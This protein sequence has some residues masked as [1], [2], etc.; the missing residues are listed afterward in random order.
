MSKLTPELQDKFIHLLELGVP[1][2]YA[3]EALNIDERTYFVWMKL[4]RKKKDDKY[5]Q[6]LQSVESIPGKAMARKLLHLEKAAEKGSVAASIW[7]LEHKYPDEFKQQPTEVNLTLKP[8]VQQLN[9]FYLLKEKE[10][11]KEIEKK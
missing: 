5:F 10:K 8:T 7:F 6:F 3:C 2:K 9:D 11:K 1:I 4:G